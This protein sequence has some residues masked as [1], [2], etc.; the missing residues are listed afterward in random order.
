[1][2]IYFVTSSK[3]KFEWAK[4]RLISL[5]I[6]LLHHP[7]DIPEIRDYHVE[8]VAS[9]KAKYAFDILKKP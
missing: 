6:K 2:E 4:D 5:D 9:H 1:M 8:N 3:S 7:L